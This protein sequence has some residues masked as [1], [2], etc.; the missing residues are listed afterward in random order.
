MFSK[1]L[2]VYS[3][4]GNNEKYRNKIQNYVS[5]H[6]IKLDK[7]NINKID[8]NNFVFRTIFKSVG[9]YFANKFKL[10]YVHICVCHYAEV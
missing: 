5:K 10:V 1:N 6:Q 9:Y 4:S 3:G 8:F 7:E 2:K